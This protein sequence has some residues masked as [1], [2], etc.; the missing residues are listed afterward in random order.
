VKWG[1]EAHVGY[2]PQD[3]REVLTDATTT[4]LDVVWNLVPT[5][6]TSS[7][8]G[9]LGRVLFSGDDVAK[10]VGALS[11]GEAA[12]LVF[13]TLMVRHPN[14][15]VLDEPT[16]H[17]DLES[18]HALVKALAAFDGTLLFVSHDRAF[19]SALATRILEVT[20]SGFRDFPGTYDEYLEKC[21]DDHLDA[22]VVV[23]RARRER[24]ISPPKPANGALSWEDQKRR[25]NRQKQ[26]PARRDKVV[27]AI[28]VA[29]ARKAEILAMWCQPGYA[30]RTLKS[31]VLA[32][33]EEERLLGPEIDALVAEWEAIEREI[34]EA[35]K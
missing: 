4:T 7:V 35:S 3:H 24:G 27:A 1:H 17:L 26:L 33:V 14:V 12:R 16:N 25:A 20:Q 8:R 2:F 32:L 34:E 21:G 29:E 9:Q 18:I 11:G 15:L 5:E 28:E 22:D 23:L 6:G 13:C 10:R 30:E 19:V 31:D